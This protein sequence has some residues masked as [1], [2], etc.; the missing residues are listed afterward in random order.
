MKIWFPLI[1]LI[2]LSS[3]QSLGLHPQLDS[4]LPADSTLPMT[5]LEASNSACGLEGKDKSERCACI[6]SKLFELGKSESFET[7]ISNEAKCGTSDNPRQE[8]IRFLQVD[9]YRSC[10]NIVPPLLTLACWD[11]SFIEYHNPC[12]KCPP[13]PY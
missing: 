10:H 6:A 5:R 3:C 8:V 7:Y 2:L 4:P 9:A 12:S 1:P 11:G 13:A